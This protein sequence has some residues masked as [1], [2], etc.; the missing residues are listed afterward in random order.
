LS[1]FCYSIAPFIVFRP[2]EQIRLDVC[3]HNKNV[4]IV[5]N[6]GGY[7]YGIMGATHHALEDFAVLSALPHLRCFVPYSN[8]DVPT[9]CD[10]MQTYVGPSYLRLGF[11]KTPEGLNDAQPWAPVRRLMAGDTCTVVGIGPVLLN[12]VSAMR[13]LKLQADL[14]AVSELPVTDWG[15][16]LE[17]S[18]RRTGKLL[19]LE[20]HVARGGLG[21]HL[22]AWCMVHGVSVRW[23]HRHASGYPN[24]RYGSQGYHQALS[25]LDPV[26]LQETLRALIYG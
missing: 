9:V 15:G 4:K 23:V 25:S 19:V 8:E 1:P 5:G 21:E 26:T 13:A 2:V 17:S 7:G 18:L 6:G 10:A 11:G 3:L 14:F 12:A 24:G 20:E 22:A 16:E